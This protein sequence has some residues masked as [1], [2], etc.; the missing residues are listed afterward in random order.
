MHL[1]LPFTS[2]SELSGDVVDRSTVLSTYRRETHRMH[3]ANSAGAGMRP[4]W[5]LPPLPE[6]KKWKYS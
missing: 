3:A 4:K 5:G 6:E 2:H 1:H